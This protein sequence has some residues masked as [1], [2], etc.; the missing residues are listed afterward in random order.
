MLLK[1]T[2]L[3]L[4]SF[5]IL[6]VHSVAQTSQQAVSF[7]N[8]GTEKIWVYAYHEG[9]FESAIPALC[10]NDGLDAGQEVS[11]TPPDIIRN[12]DTFKE[13][14]QFVGDALMIVAGLVVTV[15]TAGAGA[16]VEAGAIAEVVATTGAEAGLDAVDA[17]EAI[18]T[19]AETTEMS[20]ETTSEVATEFPEVFSAAEDS[21]DAAADM[22]SEALTQM[23][24]QTEDLADDAAD[25]ADQA[26]DDD[27]GTDSG[28]GSDPDGDEDTDSGDDSSDNQDDSSDDQDEDGDNSN[29]ED[30][31]EDDCNSNSSS[32]TK[33]LTTAKKAI[34][35]AKSLYKN[36]KAKIPDPMKETFKELR[37]QYQ[38]I[39]GP[40]EQLYAKVLSPDDDDHPID[41]ESEDPPT[42]DMAC[43]LKA[44]NKIAKDVKKLE[45]KGF[46]LIK[47][48]EKE[49]RQKVSHLYSLVHMGLGLPVP[50]Q[51]WSKN[52]EWSYVVESEGYLYTAKAGHISLDGNTFELVWT[53]PGDST[54]NHDVY[55]AK[56]S[57]PS[58]PAG[59]FFKG[60]TK[61]IPQLQAL[62]ESYTVDNDNLITVT[63]TPRTDK[64]IQFGFKTNTNVTWWKGV[65]MHYLSSDGTEKS[66]MMELQGDNHEE[67]WA[68][69]PLSDVNPMSPFILTFWKAKAFGVHTVVG[70]DLFTVEG[71]VNQDGNGTTVQF[72]WENDI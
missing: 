15:V 3:V 26:A 36:I 39:K 17:A 2:L 61:P 53:P 42:D 16:E 24:G 38:F 32:A 41:Y 45:E 28:D 12:W 69:T 20:I 50:I 29:D 35:K 63:K 59:T 27:S 44:L 22:G 70:Q 34:A 57:G 52:R 65:Q 19:A 56:Y 37:S 14:F 49:D 5:W 71:L 64:N 72:F 6:T 62:Q 68:V 25:G 4:L 51:T 67:W 66:L 21:G 11:Y 55:W 47:D 30:E 23:E 8:Q 18:E 1:K 48:L 10:Y 31:D 43:E 58:Y 7:T 46:K 9:C 33:N 54:N 60:N 40:A 13:V